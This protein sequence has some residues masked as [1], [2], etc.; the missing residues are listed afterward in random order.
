MATQVNLKKSSYLIFLTVISFQLNTCAVS[1]DDITVLDKN[2]NQIV[3]QTASD[4]IRSSACGSFFQ[5]EAYLVVSDP[6]RICETVEGLDPI[7]PMSFLNRLYW[8]LKTAFVEVA[9]FVSGV[10]LK[11][12][13]EDTPWVLITQAEENGFCDLEK[14]L[15]NIAKAG[16]SSVLLATNNITRKTLEFNLR[17]TTK[18]KSYNFLDIHLINSWDIR[19]FSKYA[20]SSSGKSNGAFTILGP[21]RE[22]SRK[23]KEFYKESIVSKLVREISQTKFLFYLIATL[24]LLSPLIY[25]TMFQMGYFTEKKS[26]SYGEDFWKQRRH[27]FE[28]QWEDNEG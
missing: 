15:K 23:C 6:L 2:T 8:T 22:E 12:E 17:L 14:K 9:N 11:E 19:V 5:K 16:Y 27:R 1:C 13:F 25:L 4:F 21:P 24:M 7:P 3:F 20:D 10:D 28:D 26:Y 18:R